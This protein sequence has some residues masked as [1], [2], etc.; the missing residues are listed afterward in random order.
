MPVIW[1]GKVDKTNDTRLHWQGTTLRSAVFFSYFFFLHASGFI[2]AFEMWRW[3]SVDQ[4]NN[5][6]SIPS[7]RTSSCVDVFHFNLKKNITNLTWTKRAMLNSAHG[8][9]ILIVF[10][11]VHV[12]VCSY[13]DQCSAQRKSHGTYSLIWFVV[14]LNDCERLFGSNGRGALS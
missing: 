6:P 9:C 2:M 11:C 10:I 14:L 3:R 12:D 13:V 1:G 4:I 5:K 8:T 7:D